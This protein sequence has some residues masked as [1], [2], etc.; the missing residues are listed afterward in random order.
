[1]S[2]AVCGP[3]SSAAQA[4]QDLDALEAR[5]DQATP[6]RPKWGARAVVTPFV[7][8]VFGPVRPALWALWAAV[9]VLLVIACANVAALMLTRASVR[10][11]EQAVRLA[12]GASRAAIGR[13]WMLEIGIIA[14]VGG[15]LGL[16]V[17]KGLAAG[18][19]ALAPDDLP[20]IGDVSINAPV[21]LFTFGIV[22]AAA[23]LTGA[24]PLRRAGDV[25]LVQALDG[26]RT[27]AG[28][29][30]LGARSALVIIQIG[31]AV[32][33][34]VA[35][36]LVVRSFIA[37][38]ADRS[39]LLAGPRPDRHRPA[40]FDPGA[41]EPLDERSAR[42][43]PRTAGRRV[44]GRRLP[45]PADA[46]ADRPGRA[47]VPRRAARNAGRR[48]APTRRSTIRS[49]RRATSRR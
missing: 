15:L 3:G 37:L 11:R 12:L 42:A 27:T 43:R 1:M 33:L 26:S 23:L 38:A 29:R 17:A 25:N 21:A 6:G 32:V 5:L 2:S 22:L 30:A 48:R 13:L 4:R 46:R 40:A 16:A 20:R 10:Q 31:L 34:L 8:Y 47:R 44:G 7:E 14:G 49:R 35:T 28:R 19:V 41:A 36:G 39:R 24:I 18:I 9:A 45:A